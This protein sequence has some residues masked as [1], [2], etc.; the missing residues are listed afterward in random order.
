MQDK[1]IH[2]IIAP[3]NASFMGAGNTLELCIEE[4]ENSM[5]RDYTGPRDSVVSINKWLHEAGFNCWFVLEN[6]EL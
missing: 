2:A 1:Y 3:D 6:S 4:L 5:D